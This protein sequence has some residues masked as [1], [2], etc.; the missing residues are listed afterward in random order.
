[1]AEHEG[2]RAAS[3]HGLRPGGHTVDG[4]TRVFNN[5]NIFQN[6]QIFLAP[7]QVR[8]KGLP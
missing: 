3:E 1:M 7:V 8:A 5:K 6:C 2:Q 4:T